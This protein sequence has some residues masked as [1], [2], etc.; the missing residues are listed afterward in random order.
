MISF[1]VPAYNEAERIGATIATILAV[2]EQLGV[3]PIDIVVV[4]DGS[5]DRTGEVLAGLASNHGC[6]QVL[7]NEKN[8][9]LGAAI[10][11]GAAAVKYARF[12][13][14]PGDN[15]MSAHT[16][17][18]LIAHRETAD[19]VMAFP[20]NIE[21]R[22]TLR[23][24]LSFLYRVFYILGFN[25]RVN[26]INAA[27]VY[28]TGRVRALNLRGRRFSF[29]AELNLKLLRSGCSFCEIP[30]YINADTRVWRTVNL[31]NLGDVIRSFILLLFEIHISKRKSFSNRPQRIFIDF[32]TPALKVAD[33]RVVER[34]AAQG[35]VALPTKDADPEVEPKGRWVE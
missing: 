22:S 16:L 12:I 26:Y 1:I 30:G 2:S 34:E 33:A 35:D 13:F 8:L 15:D 24:V 7:E 6:I 27:G 17:R 10:K 31:R 3:R 9:G 20:V 21:A 14:V 32:A 29:T 28:P 5:T 19:L 18:Q 4:N 23:N 25:A 11:R